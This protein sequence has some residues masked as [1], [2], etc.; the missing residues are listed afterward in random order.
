[1]V[2]D[3][4]GIG[5]RDLVIVGSDAFDF[6]DFH[7][8]HVAASVAKDK[9]AIFRHAFHGD[10][11]SLTALNDKVST[12]VLGTLAHFRGMNV[13]LVMK[14]TVFGS[15]HD[16]NLS[17]VNVGKDAHIG[18]ANAVARMVNEGSRHFDIHVKR[19]GVRQIA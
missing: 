7:F 9:G 14:E 10:H 11:R 3:F 5:F 2:D 19:G 1:M 8:L 17:K 18:F 6:H 13:L 15:D 16:G 12:H 4:D